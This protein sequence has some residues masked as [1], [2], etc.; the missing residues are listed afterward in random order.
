ML[1]V[2]LR[3]AVHFFSQSQYEFDSLRDSLPG[4]TL[5]AVF[6]RIL[7]NEKLLSHQEISKFRYFLQNFSFAEQKPIDKNSFRLSFVP[8]KL[9]TSLMSDASIENEINELKGSRLNEESFSRQSP[10]KGLL[11]S[12]DS[13]KIQEESKLS[14]K[15][16]MK[17]GLSKN[18]GNKNTKKGLEDIEEYVLPDKVLMIPTETNESRSSGSWCKRQKSQMLLKTKQSFIKVITPKSINREI[19]FSWGKNNELCYSNYTLESGEKSPLKEEEKD[20]FK[21][22]FVKNEGLLLVRQHSL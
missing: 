21:R 1:R 15:R 9:S 17:L 7:Y 5:A 4:L 14:P 12:I 18:K 20:N 2:G 22:S 3:K 10:P 19:S 11:K 13:Q 6:I 16:L 8:L